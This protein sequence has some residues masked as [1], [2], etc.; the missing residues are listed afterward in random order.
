MPPACRLACS[1][2]TVEEMQ[3]L[4]IKTFSGGH[5]GRQLG[6]VENLAR[7]II[8]ASFSQERMTDIPEES[9]VVYLSK[10]GKEEKDKKVIKKNPQAPGSMGN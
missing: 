5:W 7:Y 9:E 6:Q 4:F 8:R 3:P 1:V 2:Q 10:D